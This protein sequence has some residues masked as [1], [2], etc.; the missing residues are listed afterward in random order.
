M[1]D[2][3]I[4]FQGLFGDLDSFLFHLFT[5]VASL[6]IYLY[7]YFLLDFRRLLAFRQLPAFRRLIIAFLQINVVKW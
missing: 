3:Y 5:H 7:I 1:R 2:N 4:L 6:Y